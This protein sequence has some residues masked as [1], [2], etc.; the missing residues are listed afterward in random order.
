MS[1]IRFR[2]IVAS[3]GANP[4]RW[5]ADERSAALA[6]AAAPEH[7]AVL[8]E[9]AALDAL[10]KTNVVSAPGAALY[11]RMALPPANDMKALVVKIDWSGLRRWL[12]PGTVAT[13][14]AAFGA[15]LGMALM[16]AIYEIAAPPDAHLWAYGFGAP[17]VKIP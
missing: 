17:E 1:N 7:R 2:Q 9:E 4:D 16:P 6:L 8:D 13:A 5:P 12:F 15:V 3:Y 11:R 14:T 10:L